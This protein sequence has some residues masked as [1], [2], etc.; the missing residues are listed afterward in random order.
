MALGSVMAALT[1]VGP[2]AS[3]SGIIVNPIQIENRLPGTT[4][5]EIQSPAL[6]GEVEGYSTRQSV[7]PGQ[8][9]GFSV[10]TTASK[11]RL[12]IFRMG[13]YQGKGGRLLFSR[14]GLPGHAYAVP[15]PNSSTGLLICNWPVVFRLRI[16][17][18]WVTGIYLVK[19]S[20][21]NG[22]QAYIPFVV[23]EAHSR[24]GL[25]FV[26]SVATS[27]AYNYW[28][29]K[30]LYVD[31]NY[32]G[33][34]EQFKHRAVMVS[35]DRP[36][37]QNMGAGW[38]FSWEFHM[39]R[40]LE[41]EGYNVAY[42]D[43]LDVNDDPAILLRRKGIIIAGHDEYWS[44]SMR[45]AMDNAVSHGV[46]LANFAAN[47]GYWQLRFQRLGTNRDGIQICYKDFQRDPIHKQDPSLAT[48][49]WRSTQVNRPESELLGAMYED[50]LGNR[51]PYPWVVK[52]PK[53]WVF[54]GTGLT[55][56]SS[57]KGLVGPEEDAVLKR[58]PHPPGLD[59][60]SASPVLDDAHQPRTSNS[61]EYKARSGAIVFN[62]GTFDWSHGLDDYRQPGWSYEPHR[63][64][65]SRAIQMITRNVL[66]A[67][68]RTFP[69]G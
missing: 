17:A 49:L 67:M 48:V 20:A 34:K 55:K 60:L 10:R 59:I 40:W 47:T 7:L 58:Y 19:L 54:K 14:R 62:A 56:G 24:A 39:V 42:V 6:H 22:H 3:S 63:K 25:V 44:R 23:K 57:I 66:N 13:W 27:Q 12:E 35:Y 46:G 37:A 11:Y 52:A 45:D 8:F 5:W 30:S 32:K 53:S 4:S 50:Y 41:H 51:P 43:D 1:V 68:L 64:L 21:S 15:K 33:A 36:F 65:P 9:I 31:V 28:G 61:T 69:Q 2:R 26:D 29:G 18:N 16:P 38:F